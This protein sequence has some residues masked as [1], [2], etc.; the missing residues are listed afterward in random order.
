MTD[1]TPARRPAAALPLWAR[2]ALA[3][4]VAWLA[5]TAVAGLVLSQRLREL[6]FLNA[7]L[8]ILIEDERTGKKHDFCYEGGIVSFVEHLNR[9]RAPVHRPPISISSER[10]YPGKGGD[11]PVAIEI[12]LQYN[13]SYNESVY[14]FANN[15]NTVEGGSHL[16]GFRTALTRTLNRYISQQ[17]KNG[18]DEAAK[19]DGAP[20]DGFKPAAGLDA[21]KPDA[22]E[23][24]E[25]GGKAATS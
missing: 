8:R 22:K 24:K 20:K 6:S 11:V 17:A 4:L 12:A 1:A 7:G 18:K 2:I 15:I 19:T 5:A 3:V 13:E 25:A 10:S 23:P 14:S 21:G 9:S 16:V